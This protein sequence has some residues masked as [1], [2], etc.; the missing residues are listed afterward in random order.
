MPATRASRSSRAAAQPPPSRGGIVCRWIETFLV[1][2]P[3]DLYGKPFRLT[4]EQRRLIWRAHELRP[5]GRRQFRRVVYGRPKGYGKTEL[6]AALGLAEFAGPF[7]L[8]APDIPVAAASFEQAD[9]VFGAMRVMA[10]EGPLAKHLDVYDTEIL[11][12]NGP[13]RMYRVA[14]VAGTN[15]GGRHTHRIADEVHEWEGRKEK[16]YRVLTNGLAKRAGSWGLD[17]STAG[18]QLDGSLVG[19]LYTKGKRIA[20]GELRDDAFL[21]DWIEHPDPDCDLSSEESALAA[22]LVAYAGAGAHV[23]FDE[24]LG[25]W[26]ELP[27]YEFRRYYLNQFTATAEMWLPTGAWSSLAKPGDPPPAGAPV[28]L[29]FDGSYNNDSTALVGCTIPR[30]GEKPRLFVVDAWERPSQREEWVVPRDEVD[31]TV[32]ESMQRWKVRELACDPPG[33]HVEIDRWAD[34]YGDEVVVRYETNKRSFMAAACSKFY[35]GTV[36]EL[37]E[38]DGDER[39]ARH[40]ANAILKETSD[41]AYITKD[42]RNSPRK[43]DLAVAAVVAYDR[44]TFTDPKSVYSRRGPIVIGDD[45]EVEGFDDEADDL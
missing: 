3:G 28:V 13:G 42:G 1:H 21:F 43:I 34:R 33:W 14:A 30:D 41:G 29:A 45:G 7:A 11:L 25:R 2:G 6:A 39:L 4:D 17:I 27:E 44:A 24:I 10:A 22:I 12:K 26:S 40:L 15:D 35:T 31:A 32:H 36:N 23:D 16:V 8:T 18:S 37:L 19:T 38:H 20:A 5:D 9:L